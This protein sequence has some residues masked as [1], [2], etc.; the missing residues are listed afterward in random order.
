MRADDRFRQ[1]Y[2]AEFGQVFRTVFLACRDEDLANEATQ[3]AFV[4]ALE[5]W[6]RLGDAPW[7]GGWIT[8][9]ALNVVRRR[10]RRR[11]MVP[12]MGPKSQGG[13]PDAAVDL[14]R[15]VGALP[16]RLQQAVVLHYRLGLSTGEV[17]R[18]MGCEE[19]TVR[20]YLTRARAM[21]RVSLEG[22]ERDYHGAP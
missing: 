15:S 18:A 13:D 10:L 1:L 5:R 16:L 21:L 6:D 3:E 4:R 20:A 17:A 19:A 14:W 11:R 12:R 2:E 9:T 22:G 8:I 7:V